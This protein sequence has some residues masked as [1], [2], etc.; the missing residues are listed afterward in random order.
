MSSKGRLPTSQTAFT[1]HASLC[2]IWVNEGATGSH[3]SYIEDDDVDD[4]CSAAQ[5]SQCSNRK[6]LRRNENLL[7]NDILGL[8]TFCGLP[9]PF[10]DTRDRQNGSK[11]LLILTCQS[12][13]TI[14]EISI[15]CLLGVR[16]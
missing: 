4:S 13:S 2:G 12:K 10:T 9:C 1:T 3:P 7:T 6:P 15:I 8:M 11:N 14:L 16:S 5:H